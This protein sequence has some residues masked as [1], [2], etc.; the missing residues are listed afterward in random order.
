MEIRYVKRLEMVFDFSL[1][2]LPEA[3]LPEDFFWSPWRARQADAHARLVYTAF[4]N[5]VDARVFPTFRQ[6]E[7]CE[8]LTR[9]IASKKDFAPEATWL[10]G[11][12]IVG[13]GGVPTV[14]YC[15]SIQGI[16]KPE[17]ATGAIQN[18]AVIPGARRHGLG[19]ALVLK[20]LEGFRQIGCRRA[21]LEATA[22]NAIAVK[23]Y[24]KLGFKVARV[25][26]AESFVDAKKRR[27]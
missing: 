15:A 19:S 12:Q 4:R 22:E 7:A 8:R 27:F 13:R 2:P 1:T 25:L 16:V 26:Y 18:V 24:A 23:M 6:Y 21:T 14:D 11:R 3:T 17:T 5:D 9:A 20:S 10:I